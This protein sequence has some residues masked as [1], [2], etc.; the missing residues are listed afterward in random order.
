MFSI[1]RVGPMRNAVFSA[2]LWPRN[3]NTRRSVHFV[4]KSAIRGAQH[5]MILARA[6]RVFEIAF[7]RRRDSVA[8]REKNDSLKHFGG[9]T[10]ERRLF[11]PKFAVRKNASVPALAMSV[12]G[13]Q[14]MWIYNNKAV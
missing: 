3:E 5:E 2:R 6:P 8:K 14:I 7:P 13:L 10:R 4:A 1:P 9:G 11:G 12:P